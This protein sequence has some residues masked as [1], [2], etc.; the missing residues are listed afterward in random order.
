[1]VFA[2]CTPQAEEPA[3]EEEAAE[4]AV[5]EEEE[6]AE[7]EEAEP[8]EEEEE[9]MAEEEEEE[10]AE[11]EEAEEPEEEVFKLGVLGPFSGPSAQTGKQFKGGATIALEGY[12]Y[13]IGHYT[14]E[15]VWIDSQSDPAKASQA[16]EQ[17]VV[18]EGIQAGALNW[19]SSVAVAVMEVT[20]KHQVPHIFG[21]GATEK[22][23]E[24]FESD[25]EKYGYW[26]TKGWPTPAKLGNKYADAM[27]YYIEQGVYSPEA[28]TVA[29]YGE[30]T[31][32]GRS[33]G[34]GVIE[35]FEEAGWEVISEEYFP[36]EQ[37]EFYAYLNKLKD[38]NPAVIAGTSTA[39]PSITAF[40]KQA[41]EV[42]LE[43]LII[44][45][46]LGWVDFCG[47]TGD[48]AHGVIDQIAG[49]SGDEGFAFAEEFEE[50]YDLAPSTSSAGLAHDGTKMAMEIMQAV[51]DE[52]GELSS[53][54]IQDFIENNVWTGEWTM[55]DGLVMVEYK[56]TDETTPDPVVG[57]GFYTFPVLQYV[58]EDGK[59]V[60]KPIYPVEGAVMDLMIP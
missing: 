59:C 56:Y 12:D 16:Y 33:F 24:T 53:E 19:H 32:W 51:Y 42:G 21:F 18:Q 47:L 23:N 31:D 34:A 20:A 1:M 46:G 22:V 3:A 37:T 49:W 41:D 28:K 27:E 40:I 25:P 11:E 35:L 17:A 4:E 44:A 50:R 43:S 48:S 9:E 6:M 45:D 57:P 29:I 55:T 39:P 60:G 10:A 2:A 36:L 38:L 58:Y 52:H 26:S 14:I 8:A 30:D 54:L 5:E 15:P 7:E 13:K